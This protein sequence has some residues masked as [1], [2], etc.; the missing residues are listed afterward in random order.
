M[1]YCGTTGCKL[2]LRL[3]LS[4]FNSLNAI[5]NM[6]IDVFDEKEKYTDERKK[7]LFDH[8]GSLFMPA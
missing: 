3:V 5:L 8:F 4:L 7:L 2:F 1:S 6:F